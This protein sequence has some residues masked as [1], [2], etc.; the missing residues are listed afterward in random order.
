MT[1]A[2]G[3]PPLPEPLCLGRYF[4]IVAGTSTGGII[5]AF[6][7]L[8]SAGLLVPGACG[9]ADELIALYEKRAA[10]IFPSGSS[11]LSPLWFL[12]DLLRGQG[13]YSAEG[14][15]RVLEGTL[16]PLDCALKDLALCPLVDH[17]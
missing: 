5:V 8:H 13:K 6:L 7:A 10:D 1:A 17:R 4:D 12:W 14:L 15:Q 11:T 3:F 9:G 2:R 16:D